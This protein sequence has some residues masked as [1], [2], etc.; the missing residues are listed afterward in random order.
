MV[1]HAVINC[2]TIINSKAFQVTQRRKPKSQQVDKSL[3]RSCDSR[4]VKLSRTEHMTVAW[5]PRQ[6]PFPF[7]PILIDRAVGGVHGATGLD[8]SELFCANP[9][10][11]VIRVTHNAVCF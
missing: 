10:V 9:T 3:R 11:A 4:L 5:L 2:L 8:T 7:G 1:K 6:T